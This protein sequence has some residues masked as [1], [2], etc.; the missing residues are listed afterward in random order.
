MNDVTLSKAMSHA[1]RHEPAVY[2]LVLGDGGWMLIDDLASA[3]ST[4]LEH[5]I[6][7]HDIERVVDGSEKRRFE[8]DGVSVRAAYGHSV[9]DRI[10]H[11]RV[12]DAP[13]ALFHATAPG[14]LDAIFSDGLRPMGRQFVHVA[15]APDMAMVVGRRKAEAPVLLEV[16]AAGFLAAGHALY[17]AGPYVYL[18]DHVP[19]EFLRISPAV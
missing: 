3:L 17:A 2:G 10:E 8:S 5:P 4:A 16:D 11:S 19:G 6:A 18:A 14:A 9:A 1:L 13:T 15:T 7:A 12:T